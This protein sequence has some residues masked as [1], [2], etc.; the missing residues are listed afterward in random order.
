MTIFYQHCCSTLGWP[1]DAALVSSLSAD[2]KTE[3]DTL[4]AALNAA[5]DGESELEI[6]DAHIAKADFLYRIGHKD[7]AIAA[8][9]EALGL[10]HASTGQK[11]DLELKIIK[12]ALFHFDTEL[13]REHI[14]LAKTLVENG[15]DWDRRNRLKIYEGAYQMMTRDFAGAAENFLSSVATFTSYEVMDYKQFIQR[16]V[17]L[18]LHVLPRADL[19]KKVINSPDV[20]QVIR[21]MPDVKSFVDALYE[22]DYN[23]Y[24]SSLVACSDAIARDRLMGSHVNYYVKQM[25]IKAYNQFLEAYKSVTIGSMAAAFGVSVDFIDAELFRFI[26]LGRLSAKIDKTA[27]II[28][29]NRPDAKNAQYQ[30]VIKHGDA[31]LNQI[32]RLARVVN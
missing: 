14:A 31:L 5:T 6:M 21:E 17:F 28:E 22:C 3:S 9:A 2:N 18:A 29:T 13:L 23:K 11:I 10:K 1:A 8:V 25:R 7:E 15:G 4:E 30:G 19:K 20:R 32:Q 16:T 24:S 12:V 27:G 26:S